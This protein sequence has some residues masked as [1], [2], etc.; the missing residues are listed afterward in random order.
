MARDIQAFF[1]KADINEKNIKY[2][3]SEAPKTVFHFID[4]REPFEITGIT[5]KAVREYLPKDRFLNVQKGVLLAA[6]QIDYIEKNGQYHML[7]GKVIQGRKRYLRE[8]HVNAVQIEERR[9]PMEGKHPLEQGMMLEGCKIFEEMEIPVFLLECVTGNS[10]KHGAFDFIF[11]YVNPAMGRYSMMPIGKMQGESFFTVFP[12]ADK[13]AVANLIETAFYGTS[14]HMRTL[15]SQF[16][17][18][19]EIAT[20]QP[21]PMHILCMYHPDSFNQKMKEVVFGR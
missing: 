2:I 3:L 21:F 14:M 11:R 13:K 4:G 15:S 5:L 1:S 19:I 8:H 9:F 7:D 18:P 20:S 12:N 17:E 16:G 10:V 6:S